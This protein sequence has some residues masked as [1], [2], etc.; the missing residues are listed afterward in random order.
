MN[1]DRN[2]LKNIIATTKNVSNKTGSL[3]RGIHRQVEL[4]NWVTI[5]TFALPPIPI[6]RLGEWHLVSLLTVARKNESDV[7][8]Y[9]TPWGIIEWSFSDKK[10]INKLNLRSKQ[11][12]NSLWQS[13]LI[14]IQA[15]DL[16][17][18]L[19]P[20]I[21][22]MREN[23]LFSAIDSFC[24]QTNR[25]KEDFA[26]LAKHYSGLLPQEIYSYYHD[27]V[28]ESREWLI[29]D[30]PA[31]S[32]EIDNKKPEEIKP[33][34]VNFLG[35]E[36]SAKLPTDLSNNFTNWFQQ[37][38]QITQVIIEENQ[39]LGEQVLQ[40]LRQINKRRM[41]PGFRL[42]FVG[43]FSR[44]KSSLINRLLDRNILPEGALPTTATITSIMANSEEKMT[45]K[46]AEKIDIR[47]V[48]E[49]S[50]EELLATDQKGSEQDVLAH[51]VQISLNN[52]WLQALNAEIIDTPGAGDLNEQRANLVSS[53][54]NECDAAILLISATSPFSMTEA[55]FLEQEVIGRHVPRLIVAVSKL[56]LIAIHE[57]TKV[58]EVISQRLAQIANNILILPTYPIDELQSESEVLATLKMQIESL[59]SQGDR[60]IWRSRQ[61]SEQLSDWLNQIIIIAQDVISG[62][63][64]KTTEKKQLL[65]QVDNEIEKAELSW[66]NI[67]L[68][69]DKR[70]LKRTQ[71]ISN[72]VMTNQEELRENLE[73]EM[74]KVQDLKSWWEKELPF[75]LRRE[76]TII[77]RKYENLLLNLLAQDIDWLQREVERVFPSN[78]K[79]NNPISPLDTEIN[80]SLEE[81]DL[82]N[83][84]KYRILT[85][86]GSTAAM[87]GG[88]ILGGP[89][90][91][92]ASTGILLFSEQYLNREVNKQRQVLSE[93]LKLVLNR[94]F[95]V[96]CQQIS[97]RLRQL[98]QKVLDNTA[99]DH[100]TWKMTK[101]AAFSLEL[102][103][104][105]N[106]QTWQAMIDKA[107]SLRE[108]IISSLS[109]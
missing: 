68:E 65:R 105:N 92:A 36:P 24:S 21:K 82:T 108:E 48:E 98:Y 63:H 69:M 89:I 46:T 8:C 60:Q 74:Q 5:E 29:A 90:G 95:D 26:Q 51:R 61:V 70:R 37:C 103:S 16:S 49:S 83:V 28:P 43:E 10:V 72:K 64:V 25:N 88:S 15:A 54:L 42:A 3:V 58:M 40:L 23:N 93:D 86:I 6:Q 50:W 80:F 71:E 14:P 102:S 91:M 62:I 75:R 101:K 99:K 4:R 79:P 96:Y 17:I 34:Q 77:S 7:E 11:E 18:S 9:V 31:I 57:R 19:T 73:F 12:A 55:F 44:G 30:V 39:E 47:P 20:E 41:L 27:L 35:V 67:R 33:H 52:D 94:T 97:Q 107:S 109:I 32:L 66:E 106:E 87:I 53:L 100:K 59:V 1:I 56:D 38:N 104:S 84:Q 2:I 81:Q 76:L 22:T 45:V 13:Q 85:R 78:I